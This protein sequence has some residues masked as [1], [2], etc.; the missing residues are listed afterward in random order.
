MIAKD[1]EHFKLEFEYNLGD[2]SQDVNWFE[3][4]AICNVSIEVEVVDAEH[5]DGSTYES[6][7]SIRDIVI[8]DAYLFLVDR[9]GNDHDHGA[10]KFTATEEKRIHD[11]IKANFDPS[12]PEKMRTYL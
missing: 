11:Y 7:G 2:K 9:H 12:Q 6:Y 4:S 5:P 10:Y 3:G 8:E 1:T